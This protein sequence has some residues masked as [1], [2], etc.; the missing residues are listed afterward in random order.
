M[1][2]Q[3]TTR[4]QKLSSQVK[5]YLEGKIAKLERYSDRIQSCEIVLDTEKSQT[6]V[7][8][9]AKVARSR[10]HVVAKDKDVTKAID[11]A[12]DKLEVQLRKL[13]DKVK[14]KNHIRIT[15]VLDE[16]EDG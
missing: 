14:T 12:V 15:E 9:R 6:V 4:T 13:K 11:M 16:S 7:D 3:I 10:L 2:I 5:S 8:L 1:Q